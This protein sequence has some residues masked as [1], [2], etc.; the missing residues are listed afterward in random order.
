MLRLLII[1][2]A[3]IIACG[4]SSDDIDKP[5]ALIAQL[6]KDWRYVSHSGVVPQDGR[7]VFSLDDVQQAIKNQHAAPL[8]ALTDGPLGAPRATLGISARL[9]TSKN[10][11]T[12][13]ELLRLMVDAAGP[14]LRSVAPLKTATL[15][16]YPTATAQLLSPE[17]ERLQIT[18]VR[19][20]DLILT[21]AGSSPAGDHDQRAAREIETFINRITLNLGPEFLIDE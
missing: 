3:T 8:F 9:A 21:L 10:K 20:G 17:N 5:P 15:S 14:G 11:A 1:L 19:G 13:D 16:G 7:I 12:V 6:P 2:T 18:L 4:C